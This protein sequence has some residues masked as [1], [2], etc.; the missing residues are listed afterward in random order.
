MSAPGVIAVSGLHSFIGRGV[1]SRLLA[2]SPAPRVVGLDYRRPF[3]LDERVQFHRV[4]LTEPTADCRLAEIFEQERVEAVLHAAFRT[5]PT[6][7]LE[8]DHELE[9]IG[10][11]HVMHACAA[12]KIRQLVVASSTMLYGPHPDNPNFLTESHPLRGH[13]DAHAV[14]DRVQM[15]KLLADWSA[16]HPDAEVTVLRPC[17]IMGPAYWNHVVRYFALPIAPKPMGYDPLLQFVHE[18]DALAAFERALLHPQPGIYN[19]VGRGVLP[20]SMLLRLGGRRVLPLPSALL[21]Q[22]AYYPSRGQSGDPPAAFYDYLRYLW[23]ADGQ[24]GWDAFGEPAYTTKEA[25]IA[26]VSSRRMRRYR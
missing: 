15:E 16:R 1:I 8:L 14:R 3:Q 12:A 21:Y 17:W 6:P 24:R 2:R 5:N 13:P 10:S 25:W 11:L 23:V 26:F 4:D 9:T 19:V 22:I 20:L 7:D 18:D